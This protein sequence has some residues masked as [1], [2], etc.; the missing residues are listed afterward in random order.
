MAQIGVGFVLQ[1][2]EAYLELLAPVVGPRVDYFE[3]A[4]ETTWWPEADGSLGDN[5][6]A[7]RF[8]ALGR[9]YA[10]ASA[11]SK[12]FVAHG[13]GL[14]L[15]TADPADRPRQLR[16]HARLAEDQRRF[17]FRWLSDHLAVTNL[18]GEAL[19]LPLPLPPTPAAAAQVRRRLTELQ[20]FC[21]AVAVESAAH[22]FTYGDPCDETGLIN[23]IIALPG[24]H[25]LLDLYNVVMM[26]ENLGFDPHAYIERL[27]LSKVIEIHI[28]GG[29]P[30]EPGWLPSGRTYLLDS[31]ETAVPESVW[32][33]LD[34]VA[35][36]CTGLRGVTLERMEGTV[37]PDDV[38][39]I[40]DELARLR[41]VVG[42]LA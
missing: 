12:P 31:H 21:P 38:A 36:R 11:T 7:G 20:T 13:V 29:T 39:A 26:G 9:R 27:D 23:D 10:P 22:Y 18:A 15:G 17:D 30:S 6:F 2:E 4:P 19:A 16:W 33:L 14:S 37:G 8:A 40:A 25:L 24:A 41:R 1:P 35:P 32:A 5:R 3:I 42:R 28:A 34:D